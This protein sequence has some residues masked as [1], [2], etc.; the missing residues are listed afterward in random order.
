MWG[1][2]H[3]VNGV[4]LGYEVRF[5][6]GTLVHSP[7][8]KAPFE[9]Y[10]VVTDSD[11]ISLGQPI[12]VQVTCY[13]FEREFHIYIPAADCIHNTALACAYRLEQEH[14]LALDH[15]ATLLPTRDKN[16]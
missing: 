15:T 1:P 16:I 4:I 3:R 9:S 7:V 5:F 8:S 2:P 14:L 11:I 10:H 6:S 12:S 13:V